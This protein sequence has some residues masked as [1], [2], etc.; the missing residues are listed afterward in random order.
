MGGGASL[1]VPMKF[2]VVTEKTVSTESS[3]FYLDFDLL[4]LKD[5][6]LVCSQSTMP[7]EMHLINILC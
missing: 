3:C 7:S 6:S 1:M 2:S 5:H 4:A